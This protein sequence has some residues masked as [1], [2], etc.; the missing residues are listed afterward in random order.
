MLMPV[1]LE[2]VF[3]IVTRYNPLPNASFGVKVIAVCA[4]FHEKF[5]LTPSVP[6]DSV[7]AFSTK[8]SFIGMSKVAWIVVVTATSVPL[9]E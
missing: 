8:V 6:L 7:N 3:P 5:P 1:S 9:G 4:V 2:A